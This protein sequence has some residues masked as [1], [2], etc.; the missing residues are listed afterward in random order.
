MAHARERLEVHVG[1]GRLQDLEAPQAVPV[2]DLLGSSG[3]LSD[4]RQ[5]SMQTCRCN[6]PGAISINLARH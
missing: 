6:V 3:L 2:R 4:Q 1:A 5:A